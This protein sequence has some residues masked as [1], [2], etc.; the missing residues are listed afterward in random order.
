M[1]EIYR[2]H[3]LLFYNAIYKERLKGIIQDLKNRRVNIIGGEHNTDLFEIT[4]VTDSG[5]FHG[6]NAI[7][8]LK[9]A[10]HH[11]DVERYL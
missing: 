7:Y 1:S 3:I 8:Q 5:T 6:K 11:D 2:S 9:D 10:L 4:L